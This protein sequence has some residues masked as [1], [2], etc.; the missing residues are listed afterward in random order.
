MTQTALSNPMPLAH[1]EVA[2]E[3]SML[4]SRM[5]GRIDLD[6]ADV[7]N[8]LSVAAVHPKNQAYSEFSIPV[9]PMS[10]GGSWATQMLA[11]FSGNEQDGMSKEYSGSAK[12]T[13][14]GNRLPYLKAKVE[15]LFVPGIV[16]SVR[17]FIASP[18]SMIR[19]HTD[20]REFKGGFTRVHLVLRTTQDC[21]NSEG[22]S[23]YHMRQGE[24]WLL[25]SRLPHAGGSFGETTRIHLVCDL[26]PNVPVSEIFHADADMSAPI[27]PRLIN[28][29]KL[30]EQ[31]LEKLI[32]GL[33]ISMKTIGYENIDLICQ[34]LPFQYAFDTGR[35]YDVLIE[36]AKRAG[37]DALLKRAIDTRLEFMGY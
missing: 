15:Q 24:V 1:Q 27:S 19:A 35:T 23:V 16:K 11:N 21:M 13:E 8:A 18:G 9:H 31:D 7:E 14:L 30:S 10:S 3:G 22:A 37:N 28:R 4:E 25:G 36:V 29:P 6:I 12:W 33:T 20:Y 26:D 2:N 34:M 32:D 5:L 17:L